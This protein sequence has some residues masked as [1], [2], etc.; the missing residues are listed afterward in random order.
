MRPERVHESPLVPDEPPLRPVEMR[1]L[2]RRWLQRLLAHL[3][4]PPAERRRLLVWADGAGEPLPRA[5]MRDVPLHDVTTVLDAHRLGGGLPEHVTRERPDDVYFD[6]S[7]PVD[8]QQVT[9]LAASL[10]MD[11]ASVHFVLPYV[12]APPVRVEVAPRGGH[13]LVSLHAVQDGVG[14]RMLRR[15]LDL[16]GATILLVVL[17]PLMAF[18]AFLVR[19]TSGRPVI[20]V[21]QRVGRGGRLFPLYKFR[22]MVP[23]AESR[24]RASE[25]DYA[26]YVASNFKVP[27]EED[28]RITPLGH[29]LRRTSLDELPQLWNVLRGDMSLVGPRAIVPD[30]LA[31]YA[32]YSGM[33]LRVKPGLTGLWQVSGRSRIG[34]PERAR[35]DLAYVQG[36][37]V[38]DDLA[39][40][41]R[42]LP[43]VIRQRGAL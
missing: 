38:G 39:L 15:A 2:R 8:Q 36:R 25:A 41:L 24:L 40:L 21:Q 5:L 30:E 4:D 29:F 22:S 28:D 32:G 12:G 26:R 35:L 37:S 17:A 34:Y 43:A 19:W 7:S 6:L 23:D 33:L 9:A 1:R 16:V 31:E 27:V 3:V 20:H 10:L 42:T 11:G 13:T 18:V 14:G